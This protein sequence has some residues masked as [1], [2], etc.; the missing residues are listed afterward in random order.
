MTSMEQ[1]TLSVLDIPTRALQPQ[2]KASFALALMFHALK[3]Q[4]FMPMER[5]LQ[6][7]LLT[8][9]NQSIIK[10]SSILLTI[11]FSALA[12]TDSPIIVFPKQETPPVISHN[13]AADDP[14]IWIN[15]I[16]V[17]KSLIFGTDKKSGIYV[18]D[19]DGNQLSY[20]ALG[21]IN[22]IDLRIYNGQLHIVASNRSISTLDYWIFD[23]KNLY[24]YFKT[25][26]SNAFSDSIAHHHIETG[27]NVYGVCMG[28]TLDGISAVITEEEGEKVQKWNLDQLIKTDEID[29]TQFEKG[30]PVE[31]NE[32]EGCVYDDENET[33]FISREGD[34]GILKA[35]S[36][37]G[38]KYL[39]DVDSRAGEIEGDP[40]GIS[41]YK[42]SNKEGYLVVSSQGN[43]T[44]NLYN[45]K[46]P[47]QYV[48]TF[49][50]L[51]AQGIDEV[52]DT[53]GIDVTSTPLPGYPKG[54]MVA[55]D[56][57]NTNQKGKLFNQN[58]KYIS[59]KDVL[60]QIEP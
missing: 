31:G 14:A 17:K 9:T 25:N 39:Q 43:S 15:T 45:R 21:R 60:D 56:G 51:G 36:V 58:F 27:M 38:L 24:Q 35:F 32:A 42:T 47:Y 33:I 4:I 48:G 8:I 16:D 29:I 30:K 6:L 40:E 20:S 11:S 13:D 44:F 1:H 37:D 57:F 55:Q 23:Y 7:V 19:L 50:I 2:Y 22:N 53:D 49:M 12:Y 52:R 3:I 54:M 59:F 5:Y 34:K 41:I 26:P 28:L 46:T 18:Y 10:I